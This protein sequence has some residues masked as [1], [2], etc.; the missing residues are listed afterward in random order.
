MDLLFNSDI[1][2]LLLKTNGGRYRR[3]N[4]NI[5]EVWSALLVD[6]WVAVAWNRK[7]CL[8]LAEISSFMFLVLF[9]DAT[10][11]KC[12][13]SYFGCVQSKRCCGHEGWG[14]CYNATCQSTSIFKKSF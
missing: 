1:V 12:R 4:F 14:A 10:Q 7:P 5:F 13:I 9:K 6:R 3:P 2:N 11:N 8:E